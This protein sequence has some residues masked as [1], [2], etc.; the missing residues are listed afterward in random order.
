MA[1]L[2]A[3]KFSY[4]LF[5]CD[6]GFRLGRILIW[7]HDTTHLVAPDDNPSA[8]LPGNGRAPVPRLSLIG[9]YRKLRNVSH[10][11]APEDRL[12]PARMRNRNVV[13]KGGEDR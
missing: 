4:E 6:L 12:T 9:D 5:G 11:I 1:S 8:D 13:I 2:S 7:R 10:W 3:S